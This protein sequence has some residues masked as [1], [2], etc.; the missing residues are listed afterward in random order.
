MGLASSLRSA[1]TTPSRAALLTSRRLPS[2]F[3]QDFGQVH[4]SWARLY[5]DK[6]SSLSPSRAPLARP[7]LSFAFR[8][9][10]TSPSSGSKPFKPCCSSLSININTRDGWSRGPCL[11]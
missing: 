8:R 5:V 1:A 2:S 9:S 6:V 11:L 3:S 10:S 7:N 4:A